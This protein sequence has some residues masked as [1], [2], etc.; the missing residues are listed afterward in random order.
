MGPKVEP[1]GIEPP[2][3]R[4]VDD[5]DDD[6]EHSRATGRATGRRQTALQ[7]VIAA[8]PDLNGH[9]KSAIVT[10]VR[11]SVSG[12]AQPRQREPERPRVL[13]GRR[14]ARKGIKST[15]GRDAGAVATAPDDSADRSRGG[16][17]AR[18]GQ[19]SGGAP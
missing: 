2:E 5:D 9:E 1:G 18:R 6:S 8:W 14:D 19:E 3:N 7:E 10:I 17:A 12:G 4:G 16:S 15:A 13:D 11:A